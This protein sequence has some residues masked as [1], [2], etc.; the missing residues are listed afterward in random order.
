MKNKLFAFLLVI[1]INIFLENSYAQDI[2][3]NYANVFYNSC[4]SPTQSKND[5]DYSALILINCVGYISGL[6]DGIIVSQSN[7]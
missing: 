7:K 6:T 2:N 3:I 4:I 1:T 5:K